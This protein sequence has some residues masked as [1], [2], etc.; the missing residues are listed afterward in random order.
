MCLCVPVYVN[1][2]GPV[3]VVAIKSP[4]VGVTLSCELSI[5]GAGNQTWGP[6]EEQALSPTEPFPP[7]TMTQFKKLHGT[8]LGQTEAPGIGR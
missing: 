6:L 8:Q 4:G 3:P 1:E 7:A 2:Y 5:M